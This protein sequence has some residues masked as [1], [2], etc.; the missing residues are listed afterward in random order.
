MN[1]NFGLFLDEIIDLPH[2]SEILFYILIVQLYN[3]LPRFNVSR[4][5]SV[6]GRPGLDFFDEPLLPTFFQ[7]QTHVLIR[8]SFFYGS[9]F[10]VVRSELRNGLVEGR[11]VLGVILHRHDAGKV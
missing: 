6:K 7:H 9:P 3:S 2:T 4:M 11:V 10:E 1:L 5:H 8:V